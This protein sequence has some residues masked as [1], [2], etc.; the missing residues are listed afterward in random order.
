[1]KCYVL[2]TKINNVYSFVKYFDTILNKATTFIT[3]TYMY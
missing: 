2:I 1:M 3:K